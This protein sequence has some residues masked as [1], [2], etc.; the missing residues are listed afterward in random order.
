LKLSGSR[1]RTSS[2][3]IRFENNWKRYKN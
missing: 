1:R 3:R 2:S